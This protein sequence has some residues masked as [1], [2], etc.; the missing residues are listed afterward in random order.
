MWHSPLW[1]I[2]LVCTIL[3][4]IQT[5]KTERSRRQTNQLSFQDPSRTFCVPS[6][7]TAG[8]YLDQ[9]RMTYSS[10]AIHFSI[11]SHDP[12]F[13]VDPDKGNLVIAQ[14]LPSGQSYAFTVQ[15]QDLNTGSAATAYITVNTSPC[16]P[17]NT[18]LTTPATPQMT[19]P[20][21][22]FTATNCD[23]GSIVGQLT[24][25]T[26]T[27]SAVTYALGGSP[28]FTIN[29]AGQILV[30][31]TP[32]LSG[33]TQTLHVMATSDGQTSAVPVTIIIPANCYGSQSSPDIIG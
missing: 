33:T 6:P 12:N 19:Y 1:L 5:T 23:S 2:F 22:E 7:A 28:Y 32:P 4:C 20:A 18:V 14:N 13:V 11:P 16:G 3:L 17:V 29:P 21:F 30:S 15:A 27:G 8:T 24:V 26:S 25:T 9:L 10:Y 31:N